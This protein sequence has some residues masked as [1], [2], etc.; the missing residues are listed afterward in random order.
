MVGSSVG[1]CASIVELEKRFGDNIRRSE[2][3][4]CNEIPFIKNSGSDGWMIEGSNWKETSGVGGRNMEVAKAMW[5][6]IRT[7]S[8]RK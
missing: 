5:D 3:G 2:A 8:S 1:K 7:I 4:S 6:S